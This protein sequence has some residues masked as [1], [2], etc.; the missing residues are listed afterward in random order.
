MNDHRD[1]AMF[2]RAGR[3]LALWGLDDKAMPLAS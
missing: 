1:L 2:V 3:D